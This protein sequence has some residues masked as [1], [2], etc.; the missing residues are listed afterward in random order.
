MMG[1]FELFFLEISVKSDEEVVQG[2]PKAGIKEKECPSGKKMKKSILSIKHV[3]FL[4]VFIPM[5]LIKYISI[6]ERK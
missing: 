6:R 4:S 2:I 1:W 5:L 3:R